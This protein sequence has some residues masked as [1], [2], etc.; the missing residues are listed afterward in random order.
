MEILGLKVITSEE[1]EKE[2]MDKMKEAAE[3]GDIDTANQYLIIAA[4]NRR[5]LK[6]S[7]FYLLGKCSGCS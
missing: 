7:K 1:I 5:M 6:E 2:C 4:W 3:H